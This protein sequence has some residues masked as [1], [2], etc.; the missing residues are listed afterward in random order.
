MKL[1]Y[2][3]EELLGRMSSREFSE[4]IAFASLEPFGSQ[5]EY[6]GHAI[7]AMTVANRH[8]GKN[9]NTH[10]I[11]EFMPKFER[12]NQTTEEMLQIAEMFT[13]GLGGTD[14]RGENADG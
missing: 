7:T 9:E 4:W 11:D 3:V 10:R 2:T 14:L 6:L 5:A 1:G 8:R 13:A 12:H